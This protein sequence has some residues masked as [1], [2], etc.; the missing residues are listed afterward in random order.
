MAIS[1]DPKFSN[2]YFSRGLAN[3]NLGLDEKAIKD[4]N[5]A[6]SIDPKNS[7]F[8]RVRGIA[9]SSLGFFDEAFK[10]FDMTISMD[11]NNT[12]AYFGRGI[13]QYLKGQFEE[14]IKE[15]D[16]AISINSKYSLAFLY[17]GLSKR[18]LGQIEEAIMDLEQSIS[19]NPNY[20]MTYY[21]LG[22]SYLRLNNTIKA[23]ELFLQ[24]VSIN[25]S[26]TSSCFAKCYLGQKDI[27][28]NE[29]EELVKNKPTKTNYY[30]L[31]SLYAMV[32]ETNNA[33]KNLDIALNKG[34]NLAYAMQNSENLDYI[35]YKPEYEALLAKYH[36]PNINAN[37]PLS[38]IITTEVKSAMLRWQDKGEFE[39]NEAYVARMKT[40]DKAVDKITQE[41]ISQMKNNILQ[42]INWKMAIISKYDSEGQ[43]FMITYGDIYSIII[44]VPIADAPTF[45]TNFQSY[46]I[47]KKDMVISNEKWLISELI[48][49]S[50]SG[51]NYVYDLKNQPDYNPNQIFSL[52]FEA[53]N[54]K[55]D[56]FDNN[57]T[58]NHLDKKTIVIGKDPIDIDIPV[59]SQSNSKTFVVII[60]NENYQKEVKVE[61]AANDGKVFR[62]YCE[63]TLG[64]PAKNIHFVQDASFGNMKSEIKW[65]SDVA[66]AFNSQAKIIFYY[67]GH[68]MPNEA[69]KSAYLL[70]VDGFSSDYET[71]IKLDDLY[72]R[73]NT[74]PTLSVTVFLDACFSGSARE[75]AMLSNA[76]GVKI[77][78]K[79]ESMKGNLVVFSGATGDETAYPYKEK[80]HGLFTYFLPL[81]TD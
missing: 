10:D 44:K 18:M 9:N 1:I 68:G 63:K 40:R 28:F 54:I 72:T 3:Q 7:F 38:V 8:Y 77:K 27:A 13:T 25:D 66:S 34:F 61:F 5:A 15:Y 41:V 43:S 31:A 4:Y 76:R 51:K 71:A 70:P 69:D 36:I 17:R 37:T 52:N 20:N 16:K 55:V 42:K 50:P 58:E 78:P 45:K 73:L 57:R 26:Q 14:S 33:I 48:Y 6:I 11:P 74:Y 67:A 47:S 35:R 12:E 21:E 22:Y 79:S 39:T 53:L 19:I 64:I 30:A 59:N 46:I 24:C 65:I 62:D 75:N 60:A 81:L 2:A 32:G 56:Q 29:M 49:T 80:Q 23:N